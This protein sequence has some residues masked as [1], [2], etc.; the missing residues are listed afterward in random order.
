MTDVSSN[1]YITDVSS[2]SHNTTELEHEILI[3]FLQTDAN[4]LTLINILI[5]HFNNSEGESI[6]EKVNNMDFK[7]KE[8]GQVDI[9][10]ILPNILLLTCLLNETKKNNNKEHEKFVVSMLKDSWTV[11]IDTYMQ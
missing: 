1:F 4:L 3:E 2:N 10:C 7:K 5:K 9:N 11:F 8:N 6:I